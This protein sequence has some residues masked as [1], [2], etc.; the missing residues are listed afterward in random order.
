M[1]KRTLIAVA[2]CMGILFLW[3]KIFPPGPASPPPPPAAS[4]A[5]SPSAGPASPSP[6]TKPAAAPAAENA[7]GRPATRAPEQRLALETADARYLFSS[8][9][10][11]LVEAKLKEQKFLRSKGDPASGL[12][13]V[14]GLPPQASPLKVSFPKGTP[15]LPE[16]ASW[17]AS[18]PTPQSLVF[19]LETD[20]VAVE[21]RYKVESGRYQLSLQIAVEN[22]SDRP[23]DEALALHLYGRQD[24]EATSGGFFAAASANV[25]EMV[26]NVGGEIERNSIESLLKETEDTAGA[27]RWIAADEKF[28]TLAAV[29]HVEPT[30]GDRRC[31]QR[32][33]QPLVGEVSLAFASRSIPP[34]G[35]TTYAVT[36]FAGPKYASELAQ[37][38][39]GGQAAE[40]EGLVNV[41][42]AVLARPLLYL[43]KVFHGW[44]GNWGLAI[45]LLTLFVKLLTFY[46]TQRAMMS[47]KKMQ[48]LAP[49]LA[50]I[51]KKF[52]N[53]RQRQG[54]E[55]MNL[56]KAHGVSPVGG[57]LPSLITMPIWIAL[58]S[59]LNYAVEL[60]RA[61]F[62]GYI[63]DLSAR[64][65]YFLTPLL[66]GGIMF[67]QMRMSPAGADPQQQKMMAILMPVM[68]TGFS[69]F[70][71]A[72]LALYTL[73]NSLLAIAQQFLV[74]HLDRRAPATPAP[75]R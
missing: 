51:R 65:P 12:V 59:T 37:V 5:T 41:T 4:G 48:R 26:C 66:M 32:A 31:L 62:F 40:L 56:Y 68:F 13:I 38:T 50:T 22:R 42:F 18:Q 64:D 69:L 75:A 1:E 61:P 25:A 14:G 24:P 45:I 19:R 74:N 49:E 35:S 67:L 23:L 53:D 28:F 11:T 60:Y 39:P 36:I 57:C 34:K 71:P 46:P 21:K 8:W 3:W 44:V 30:A 17:T 72:G 29:P 10:G 54:V 20:E 52:E 2:L 58:F 73:T 27:V 55:T 47:G 15:R 63:Q 16:D 70:L 33:P 9:G 7:A 43:L 6:E